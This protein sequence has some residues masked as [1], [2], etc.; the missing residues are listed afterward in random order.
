MRQER[1]T[2]K[3]NDRET[4]GRPRRKT[5]GEDDAL[6]AYSAS[7]SCADEWFLKA[8]V[9]NCRGLAFGFLHITDMLSLAASEFA[10]IP[11]AAC[12]QDNDIINDK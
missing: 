9:V 3:H 4:K 12:P 5:K 11:T 7:F 2:T 1:K 8:G 10:M 6:G